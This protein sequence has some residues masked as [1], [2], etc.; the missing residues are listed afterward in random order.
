MLYEKAKGSNGSIHTF[1]ATLNA[2]VRYADLQ[3]AHQVFTELCENRYNFRHCVMYNHV[4]GFAIRG[5]MKGCIGIV[6]MMENSNVILIFDMK[7][8]KDV[9]DIGGCPSS[10]SVIV[11]ASSK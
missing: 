1:A 5:D 11:E 4:R 8:F 9:R 2:Y 10:R 3:G 7:Y 6:A